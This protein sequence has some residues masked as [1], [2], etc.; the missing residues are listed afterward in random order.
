MDLYK[1]LKNEERIFK[2][3]FWQIYG[4]LVMMK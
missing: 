4:I 2:V 3:D 1:F